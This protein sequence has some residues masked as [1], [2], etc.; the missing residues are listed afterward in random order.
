MIVNLI[1]QDNSATMSDIVGSVYRISQL[2]KI[3]VREGL[4]E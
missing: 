1:A 3:S 4:S 2:E